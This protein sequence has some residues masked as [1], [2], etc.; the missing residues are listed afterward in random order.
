[1]PGM[2][3]SMQDEL[4][5]CY[6]EPTPQEGLPYPSYINVSMIGEDLRVLVRTRGAQDASEVHLTPEMATR[7][8]QA[9][10]RTLGV[11]RA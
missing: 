3:P 9:I 7:L 4:V 6:T 11:Q 5:Y 8:A 1:M 2:M 10:F